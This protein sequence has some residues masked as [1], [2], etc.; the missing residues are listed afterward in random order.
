MKS[1]LKS[2][3][4]FVDLKEI[5][6]IL[7]VNLTKGTNA[8]HRSIYWYGGSG[9]GTLRRV[10]EVLAEHLLRK[11]DQ[12]S[13]LQKTTSRLAGLSHKS[14][15]PWAGVTYLDALAESLTTFAQKK[16]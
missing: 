6:S 12:I 1:L 2:R 14:L 7:E 11:R 3:Y 8:D 15:P 4:T 9:L 16:R 13:K 5:A 10:A